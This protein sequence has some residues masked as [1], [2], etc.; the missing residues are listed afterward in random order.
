[1]DCILDGYISNFKWQAFNTAHFFYFLL[2][3]IPPADNYEAG[4]NESLE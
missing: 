2:L 3:Q 1:M 4:L